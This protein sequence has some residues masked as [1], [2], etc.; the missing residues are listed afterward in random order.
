MLYW[1]EGARDRNAVRF[2]NSDPAMIRMFADFLRE[3]FDVRS[4]S[5]LVTVN[6]FADHRDR[7]TEIEHHWLA[8]AGV[9]LTSLRK[10]TVN[11]RSRAS[12]HRR[13]NLLAFGT[14][15]LTVNSTEVVQAIYGA[16]QELGGFD[17]PAWLG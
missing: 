8:T 16:I 14:C 17:R 9:P 15:R 5:I 13:T 10:S 3:W 2:T 7:Q 11:T 12:Q 1:A 4:A 6:L